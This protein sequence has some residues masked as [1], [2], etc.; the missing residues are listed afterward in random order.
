VTRRF[1]DEFC[2][3]D[4]RMAVVT[5]LEKRVRLSLLLLLTCAEQGV[6]VDWVLFRKGI[7][8]GLCVVLVVW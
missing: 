1:A 8:F 3:G 2:N 5:L 7:L 6:D 4:R